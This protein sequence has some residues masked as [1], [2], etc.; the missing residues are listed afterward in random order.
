MEVLSYFFF[1]VGNVVINRVIQK[2]E[3]E[4]D[5]GKKIIDEKSYF[6][7]NYTKFL[8]LFET[9][10]EEENNLKKYN[11]NIES[12]F[13]NKNEFSNMLSDE[14]N[15]IE[16]VWKKRVLYESTPRGN[17]IMY[18][19]VYKQ[20]FSYYSDSSSVAYDILNAVAMKY[21]YFFRCKDFFIDQNIAT[22]SPLINIHF[23]EEKTEKQENKHD[24][25]RF[26]GAPF[27][28][29]KNY[30]TAENKV[31]N[32]SGGN[33]GGNNDKKPVSQKLRNKFIHLGKVCNFKLTQPINKKN[34]PVNGFK[35]KLLDT[36][37]GETQLQK[38][39][40]SY[41]NYKLAM[42]KL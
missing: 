32:N 34:N 23:V 14:N 18:Y 15:N 38:E 24:A 22:D 39:V 5:N 2:K 26:D 33:S 31:N 3:V 30:N 10:K 29:F 40:L 1:V 35:S 19:D 20:G 7:K 37:S 21:V 6:I 25:N 41:K 28:K 4:K 9:K 13:Y 27:A 16:Q 12:V 36:L 8:D 42:S 17:I 11:D